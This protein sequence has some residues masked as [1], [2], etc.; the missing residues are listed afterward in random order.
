MLAVV[1]LTKLAAAPLGDSE[2]AMRASALALEIRAGIEKHGRT[3]HP[4]HGEIYVYETDGLG[5]SN[6]MD[7][8]N[9]PSLHALPYLGYCGADDPIYQNTRRFVLS[10][11]NPCYYCGSAASGI[12]SPHTPKDY[13]WPIS[14]CMQGL[15]STSREEQLS[16]LG[17]LLRTDA[18]TGLMHES[19]HKDD[20]AQFTRP[21]FAWANSLFAELVMSMAGV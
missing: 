16:L 1:A 9:V 7:D 21:W 14:L 18:G 8:A 4:R 12:G 5:N 3:K 13:I 17:T 15:T 2:L 20:P 6:L 10:A 11:D 19:F